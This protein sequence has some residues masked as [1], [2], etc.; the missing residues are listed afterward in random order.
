[1]VRE[2]FRL[3]VQAVVGL[4]MEPV[5]HMFVP[6]AKAPGESPELVQAAMEL[7]KLHLHDVKTV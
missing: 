5:N 3:D 6:Y 7:A 1:M 4:D 2:M